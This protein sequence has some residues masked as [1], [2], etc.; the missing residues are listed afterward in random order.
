M[1]KITAILVAGSLLMLHSTAAISAEGWYVGA[2][3]GLSNIDAGIFDETDLGLKIFGGYQFNK[4]LGLEGGY[5]DFGTANEEDPTG[6]VEVDLDG[7]NAYVLGLLPVGDHLEVFGKLGAIA[8]NADFEGFSPT[9]SDDG[10]DFAYGI[11]L[12]GSDD[13]HWLARLE[14]EAFDLE[15]TDDVWL[16]SASLIYGF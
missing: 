15:D 6:R 3:M 7:F 13:E 14:F 5:S 11:G 2:G 9:V 4:Y 12:Q 8:W 16:L 10:T 1:N